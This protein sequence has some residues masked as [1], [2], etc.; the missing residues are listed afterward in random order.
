MS[1]KHRCMRCGTTKKVKKMFY[2]T[3]CNNIM[4]KLCFEQ[5]TMSNG[6]CFDCNKLMKVKEMQQHVKELIKCIMF[7]NKEC[8]QQK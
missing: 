8:V 4:C 1:K 5:D 6:A 3:E 2:C 7:L